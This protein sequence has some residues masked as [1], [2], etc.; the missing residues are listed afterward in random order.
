M[1]T[2]V[3]KR[4]G[5]VAI[6]ALVTLVWVAGCGG[7]SSISYFGS[8]FFSYSEQVPAGSTGT[9][10]QA[11]GAAFAGGDR[12]SSDPCTLVQSRKF[13]RISMSNLARSDYVH[14]FL[15]LVAYVNGD[16]YPDG[17]VCADD[18][19]LYTSFGY[20]LI[21]EGTSREFGN[22]CFDGPALLYFHEGGQFRTA[23]GVSGAQLASAIPPALGTVATYDRFFTSAG[24][25]VPAPD[26]IIFHNPGTGDGARLKISDNSPEPCAIGLIIAGDPDCQQDAFYY[27]DEQDFMSGSTALGTGSGRR[28]PNE[29]QDTGCAIGFNDPWYALAPAGVDANSA[30]QNEF[31]RGGKIDFVFL[32][33]DTD[34]PFPQMVWRVTDESGAVVHDF[35]PRAN[36][37]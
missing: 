30:T 7:G 27:V 5:I 24:T 22:F 4:D 37:P 32:R 28:V 31:I 1:H 26:L 8:P 9:G 3:S 16:V 29:L 18:V 17:A 10:G 33:E 36:I 13:V 15:V 19:A 25:Q 14:Y 23:G 11:G 35:D 12:F 20:V 34:P 21:P 2:R 6:A